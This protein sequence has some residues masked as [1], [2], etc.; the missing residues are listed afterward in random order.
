MSA[1]YR[2]NNWVIPDSAGINFITNPPSLVN[3][4]CENG[5]CS[6]PCY[7]L[8]NNNSISDETIEAEQ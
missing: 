4:V 2:G 3:T 5:L 7:S 8:L 1:Q 6:S